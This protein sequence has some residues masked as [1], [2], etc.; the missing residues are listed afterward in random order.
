MEKIFDKSMIFTGKAC[1]GK[2]LIANFIASS[3]IKTQV[4]TYDG[5][6]SKEFTVPIF[7]GL[8]PG[9]KLIIIDDVVDVKLLRLLGSW[10]GQEIMI[11]KEREVPFFIDCPKFLITTELSIELIKE[12]YPLLE[13]RFHMVELNKCGYAMDGGFTTLT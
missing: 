6:N 13:H 3:F 10:L 11:N 12:T 4:K 1:T 2:S 8:E 5:R 7:D 9:C